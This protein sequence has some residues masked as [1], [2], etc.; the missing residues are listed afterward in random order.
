MAYI[1]LGDHLYLQVPPPISVIGGAAFPSAWPCDQTTHQCLFSWQESTGKGL[2][3]GT[4]REEHSRSGLAVL[5]VDQYEPW[6]V[7]SSIFI[8]RHQQSW[9]RL[10]QLQ[11]AIERAGVSRRQAKYDTQFNDF[12]IR[13]DQEEAVNFREVGQTRGRVLR[14]GMVIQLEH[15]VSQGYMYVSAIPA[16][17]DSLS[18]CIVACSKYA[19]NSGWFRVMPKLQQV[20]CDGERVHVGDQCVL[21]HVETGMRV[22][23]GLLPDGRAMYEVVGATVENTSFRLM[24]YR[25]HADVE[26]PA[27]KSGAAVYIMHKEAQARFHRVYTR[28]LWDQC[29]N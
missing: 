22:G 7:R 5:Y 18:G 12:F 27:V 8:I 3:H 26:S 29:R 6:H 28:W 2:L 16:E 11:Q 25:E 14:Y 13:A 15:A 20:H 23:I 21:E 19:A 17:T 9:S 24:R 10:I 1:E 4:G